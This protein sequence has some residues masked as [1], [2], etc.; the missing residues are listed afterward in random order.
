M[1]SS[2]WRIDGQSFGPG[3]GV[4]AH[5]RQ[6]AA[7][8]W[9][10]MVSQRNAKKTP[11]IVYDT[12]RSAPRGFGV[13]VGAHSKTYIV[14]RRLGQKVTKIKIRNVSDYPRIANAR[15]AA[16]KKSVRS[17]RR[18]RR[19]PIPW[20]E[21]PKRPTLPERA[22]PMLRLVAALSSVETGR[23]ARKSIK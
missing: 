3:L 20:S 22:A 5:D 14:Q 16:A 11:Y 9:P 2:S 10:A 15:E 18:Q 21:R 17:T 4:K 7:P 13:K 1:R 19:I 12:H 6:A 23:G 8:A